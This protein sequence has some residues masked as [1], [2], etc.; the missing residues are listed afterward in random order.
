MHVLTM[1]PAPLSPQV[2]ALLKQNQEKETQVRTLERSLAEAKRDLADLK[3]L[4]TLFGVG[5]GFLAG[6]SVVLGSGLLSESVVS[7]WS[8]GGELSELASYA[9]GTHGELVR[10]L[11]QSLLEL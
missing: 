7:G 3:L 4:L 5:L 1:A 10:S 6:S 11:G 9:H 2:G 8:K